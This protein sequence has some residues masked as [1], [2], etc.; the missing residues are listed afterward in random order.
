MDRSRLHRS[1]RSTSARIGGKRMTSKPDALRRVHSHPCGTA[2]RQIRCILQ[3]G[4]ERAS[5][6]CGCVGMESC[7]VGA[8]AVV[9]WALCSS[10][11]ADGVKRRCGWYIDRQGVLWRYW[12]APFGREAFSLAPSLSLGASCKPTV[13]LFFVFLFLWSAVKSVG[14]IRQVWVDTKA[15]D[16]GRA[17]CW[18]GE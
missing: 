4:A 8:T 18:A 1:Q 17:G 16:G 13:F 10:C 3:K 15:G 6:F 5:P 9:A 2:V 14:L 7:G 12:R 11:A